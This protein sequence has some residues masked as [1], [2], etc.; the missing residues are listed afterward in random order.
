MPARPQIPHKIVTAAIITQAKPPVGQQVL[1]AQR[2]HQGLLGGLWEFPGGT[3]ESGEDL[4][5]CLQREI[6]EELGAGIL[7][8]RQLGVYKHAYTH[9]RITLHAFCCT[10]SNGDQPKPLEALDLRWV[11]PSDLPDYP[12]GKI[13]RQI[14]RD[15]L[16]QEVFPCRI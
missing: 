7:V 12:M 13:D 2:P 16:A 11:N 15:L 6:R 4:V 10:L 9:F 3:L 1:I 8:H 14:S 5:T